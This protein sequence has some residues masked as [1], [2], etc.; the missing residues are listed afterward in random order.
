MSVP[1]CFGDEGVCNVGFWEESLF[2]F[3]GRWYRGWEKKE[4]WTKKFKLC[5]LH[6]TPSNRPK[7]MYLL[8]IICFILYKQSLQWWFHCMRLQACVCSVCV[9]GTALMYHGRD[10]YGWVRQLDVSPS[11]RHWS[12]EVCVSQVPHQGATVVFGYI[13]GSFLVSRTGDVCE[14]DRS[15]VGGV[16]RGSSGRWI[17]Q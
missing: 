1:G 12:V 11:T 5:S 4:S 15:T 2:L 16:G 7:F 3:L 14:R 17:W 13:E 6:D 10:V 8:C 9:G